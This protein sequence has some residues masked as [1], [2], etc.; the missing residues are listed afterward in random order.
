MVRDAEADADAPMSLEL[1]EEAGLSPCQNTRTVTG[2]ARSGLV[3]VVANVVSSA[4]VDVNSTAVAVNSMAAVSSMAVA[5]AVD[6]RHEL[7]A[8]RR[9]LDGSRSRRGLLP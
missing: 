4:T 2:E 6:C 8:S 5:V 3:G 1:V 7:D 9:E